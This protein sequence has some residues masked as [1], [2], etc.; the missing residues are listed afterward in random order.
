VRLSKFRRSLPVCSPASG[1]LLHARISRHHKSIRICSRFNVARQGFHPPNTLSCIFHPDT[2][3]QPMS[4]HF[5]NFPT[6][7][8]W[9][10]VRSRPST[11]QFSGSFTRIVN[12]VIDLSSSLVYCPHSLLSFTVPM[13]LHLADIRV[14]HCRYDGNDGKA[15]SSGDKTEGILSMDSAPLP[16]FTEACLRV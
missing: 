9:I 7:G 13:D 16:N 15:R 2:S 3:F 14:V 11:K 5:I 4:D 10:K 8:S 6:Q 1:T 12:L